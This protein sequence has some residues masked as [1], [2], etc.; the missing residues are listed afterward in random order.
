MFQFRS[1]IILTPSADGSI[2]LGWAKETGGGARGPTLLKDV[3]MRVA[4]VG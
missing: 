3:G 2:A 4:G 1:S